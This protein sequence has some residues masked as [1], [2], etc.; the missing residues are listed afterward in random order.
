MVLVCKFKTEKTMNKKVKVVIQVYIN[1]MILLVVVVVVVGLV[2]V[3]IQSLIFKQ[4]YQLVVQ[5]L[6]ISFRVV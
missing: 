6:Q 1:L 5:L 4:I 3:K 2:K